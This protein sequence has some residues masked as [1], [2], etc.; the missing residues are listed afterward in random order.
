MLNVSPSS[1]RRVALGT[2][3]MV[4]TTLRTS[5]NYRKSKLK[6]GEKNCQQDGNERSHCVN[7]E[8]VLVQIQ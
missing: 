2:V 5:V 1:P 8:Q 6:E 7:D 3:S 4:S